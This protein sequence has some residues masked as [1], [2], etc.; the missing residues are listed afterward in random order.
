M[1]A[2]LWAPPD[3]VHAPSRPRPETR[4]AGTEAAKGGPPLLA[5]RMPR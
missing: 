2:G 5:A 3:R 1:E 4:E